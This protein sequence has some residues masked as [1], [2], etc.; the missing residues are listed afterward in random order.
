MAMAKTVVFHF[1]FLR[2][3][4]LD[5]FFF[6]FFPPSDHG[7]G[8]LV[9]LFV[10]QVFKE[11]WTKVSFKISINKMVLETYQI[12]CQIMTFCLDKIATFEVGS[13][14]KQLHVSPYL[15]SYP[16]LINPQINSRERIGRKISTR[17]MMD[18][19]TGIS[20]LATVS[21]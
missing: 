6:F 2:W 19:A 5:C 1:F 16:S 12:Y 3:D 21:M 14:D 10:I 4:I 15:P 13:Y 7:C 17:K 18:S 11:C 8:T 20:V 9:A